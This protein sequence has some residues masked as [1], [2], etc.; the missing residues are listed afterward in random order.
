[1]NSL[2]VRDSLVDMIFAGRKTVLIR[3]YDT[4]VR[5]V[6]GLIREGSSSGSVCGSARIFDSVPLCRAL[7]DRLKPYHC[8][9]ISY[10]ELLSI[11]SEPYVWFLSDIV[12]YGEPF[13][14]FISSRSILD[15]VI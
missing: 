1:M 8:I 6:V 7:Y 9:R 3:G 5:G 10:D 12:S 11:Y 15:D 2:V 13:G 14:C 4:E